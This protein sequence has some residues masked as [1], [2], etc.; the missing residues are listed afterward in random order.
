M[1][2]NVLLKHLRNWVPS[3]CWCSFGDTPLFR[4]ETLRELKSYHSSHNFD[5]TF[6]TAMV[7]EPGSYGRLI[8]D[9]DGNALRL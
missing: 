9:V 5:V 3:V 2:F 7:D 4:P 1:L 6:V 8:R